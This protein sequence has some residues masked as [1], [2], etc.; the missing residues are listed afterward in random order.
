MKLVLIALLIEFLIFGKYFNMSIVILV[1][2][3]SIEN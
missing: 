1:T 2:D 3:D